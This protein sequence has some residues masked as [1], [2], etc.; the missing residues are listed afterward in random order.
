MF[1]FPEAGLKGVLS[2]TFELEDSDEEPAVLPETVYLKE[3]T[4]K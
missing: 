2:D 4:T 1:Q 3:R